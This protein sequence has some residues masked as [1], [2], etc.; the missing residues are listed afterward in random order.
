MNAQDHFYS[1]LYTEVIHHCL[2]VC[3]DGKYEQLWA[4][5]KIKE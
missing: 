4:E 1:S 2:A 3:A 5:K